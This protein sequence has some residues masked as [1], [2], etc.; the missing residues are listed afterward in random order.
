MTN[1]E[2]INDFYRKRKEC[3]YLQSLHFY[4]DPDEDIC[5]K[6]HLDIVLRYQE[7]SEPKLLIHFTDVVDYKS[8]NVCS[9]MGFEI[10]ITDISDH[11]WEGIK[12]RVLEYENELLSFYCNSFEVTLC[13]LYF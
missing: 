2:L 8:A 12:Y 5:S 7:D 13:S 10:S 11:Q 4:R 9:L 6:C 3:V 1:N